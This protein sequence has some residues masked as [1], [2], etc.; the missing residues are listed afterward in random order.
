VSSNA[1]A[2]STLLARAR[3]PVLVWV[4]CVVYTLGFV[5]AFA[6]LYVAFSGAIALPEDT[7]AFYR[8][9]GILNFAG[10]ALTAVLSPIAVLQLFRLRKNAP[11]FIT[12][13][14]V[15]TIVKTIWYLPD[16]IRLGHGPVA[17]LVAIGVNGLIVYYAWYL[18]RVHVLR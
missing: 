10:L 17:Q 2:N 6:G 7:A 11:F 13:L 12:A 15:V 16:L 9:F 3:R 4:I 5:F 14:Y 18:R 1:P 8:A